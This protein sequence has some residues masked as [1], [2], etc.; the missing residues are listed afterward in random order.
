[1]YSVFFS[2]PWSQSKYI[3]IEELG[4]NFTVTNPPLTSRNFLRMRQFHLEA[5][6][7]INGAELEVLSMPNT[8]LIPL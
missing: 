7:H 2:R 4:L 6:L 8:L 1:M 5:Q 3:Y